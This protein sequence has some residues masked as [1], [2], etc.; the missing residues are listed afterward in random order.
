MVSPTLFTPFGFLVTEIRVE[1]GYSPGTPRGTSARSGTNRFQIPRVCSGV[2]P[3]YSPGTEYTVGVSS[4][5]TV[6]LA[7]HIEGSA[8]S[9][10][11]QN[12]FNRASP[13]CHTYYNV[14]QIFIL[15]VA[16]VMVAR[17]W[18]TSH[19]ISY[20]DILY[21]LHRAFQIILDSR[22]RSYKS[23]RCTKY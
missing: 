6:K 11:Y 8:G 22:F 16:A 1:R 13:K 23:M 17:T 21:A 2:S 19:G 20:A 10:Q 3:G 14:C 18:L 15:A 4:I 12:T 7:T 5:L 9:V